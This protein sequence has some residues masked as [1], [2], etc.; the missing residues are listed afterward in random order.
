M[1]LLFKYSAKSKLP[2]ILGD[3]DRRTPLHISTS[4]GNLEMT[5]YLLE[6]GALVHKKDRNNETP[7]M[8]AINSRNVEVVRLLVSVGAHI[9]LPSTMIGEH[10]CS[11]AKKGDLDQILC[12]LE[13]GADLNL[14]D[15]SGNTCLEAATAAG[16]L[17][18]VTRLKQM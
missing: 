18:M 9:S 14:R 3:Y 8:C 10:L 1:I 5:K 17:G 6:R 2:T 16:H 15:L 13:A 11:A 4:E 12:W 7:L